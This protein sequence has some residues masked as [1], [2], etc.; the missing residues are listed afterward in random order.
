MVWNAATKY[1]S[2][3]GIAAVDPAVDRPELKDLVDDLVFADS[4]EASSP[5]GEEPA[6]IWDDLLSRFELAELAGPRRPIC[7]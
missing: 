3:L 2:F 6:A 4:K 5:G 7:W 1:V